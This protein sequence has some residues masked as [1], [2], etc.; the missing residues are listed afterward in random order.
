M[1]DYQ[2]HL[3]RFLRKFPSYSRLAWINDVIGEEDYKTASDALEKLALTQEAHLWDKRVQLS[4]AKI[5]KLA[6]WE[7]TNS[8]DKPENQLWRKR[9]DELGELA[10]IQELLYEHIL[11]AMHGAIDQKAELDLAM[12][13]FGNRVGD[14]PALKELLEEFLA[15]LINGQALNSEQLI[16]LMTLMDDEVNFLEGEESEALNREFF[17]ALRILRLS[18]YATNDPAGYDYLRRLIWRRCI[19]RDDWCTIL[20]SQ[21]QS[22]A[23][24]KSLLRGTA[25]VKTLAECMAEGTFGITTKRKPVTDSDTESSQ[26]HTTD[27]LFRLGKPSEVIQFGSYELVRN[28]FRAEQWPHIEKDLNLEIDTLRRFVEDGE[29]DLWYPELVKLVQEDFAGMRVGDSRT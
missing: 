23:D 20:K 24:R 27:E 9:Q 14:R 26:R 25:L 16:N 11:P 17:F 7:R 6:S 19:I 15:Q 22:D 5:T 21:S 3:T 10:G 1:K 12:E 18:D 13:H 8:L 2:L 4:L 28:R 29:L